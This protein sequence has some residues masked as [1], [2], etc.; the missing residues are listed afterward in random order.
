MNRERLSE[1]SETSRGIGSPRPD[2]AHTPLCGLM[3]AVRLAGAPAARSHDCRPHHDI[4]IEDAFVSHILGDP[5]PDAQT[6]DD[7]LAEASRIVALGAA[8]GLQV[9][10]LGGLAFHAQVRT[11]M[12][13]IERPQRDIDLATR[14][15]DRR[16]LADLLGN[17]GYEPDRRQNALHGHKQLYFADTRT[18]RPVDV[19]VERLEMCHRFE[20]GDRLGLDDFTLARAD[21]LLS[22]LQI[23][24]INRKDLLDIL[25]LV[26]EH[27]L[28]SD[29]RLGINV[30]RIV[31]L[32]SNDWGWWR[33]VTG[34]LERL[35]AFL[36]DEVAAEEL[37][38]G[39]P[40]RHDPAEQL[41]VIRTTI[42]AA[43]K[44]LAWRLRARLG[45]RIP[46][47]DEPEEM[48]HGPL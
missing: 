20:F 7:P 45:D 34:N 3:V 44:P 24:K 43:P 21:L 47:Y 16:A 23:V 4:R 42:D 28:V 46:W 29:D 48:A 33:T 30:E 12:A 25:I 13:A 5:M 22:K 41:R 26:R 19:L 40:A 2:A 9:R 36:R 14:G 1:S 32:T 8:H 10:L 39:T 6:L 37:E 15:R 38:T 31:A 35:A 11:W 18:G 27:D 17:A